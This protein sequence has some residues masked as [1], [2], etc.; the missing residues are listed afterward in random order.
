MVIFDVD[1]TLV[2]ASDYQGDHNK[3]GIDTWHLV[4]NSLGILDEHQRLKDKFKAGEYPSY[5]EWTD[6]A[7]RVLKAH[8]LTE[9]KFLEIINC[10]RFT[11]GA[12]ETI[13]ELKKQGYKTAVITGSFS[14]L[15]K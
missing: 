7:C 9:E 1:G 6:E 12:K 3:A 5:M 11:I 15:A 4:F 10:Q 13:L 14:A 8:G 2:N